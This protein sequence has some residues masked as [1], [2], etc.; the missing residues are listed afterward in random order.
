VDQILSAVTRIT[1]AASATIKGVDL[2]VS[3]VPIDELTLTASIEAM[4][5]RYNSFSDGTF[6]V[7]NPI[8]GGN[9]TLA[10][11]PAPASIPCGGVLPPNYNALTGSWD[12]KGNH[13][14]Q[15]PPFS[16]SMLAQYEI[17]TRSGRFDLN[18]SWTH[19]GHYYADADNG[20]GQIPPS[21]AANDM[22]KLIDVLNASL[23]WTSNNATL[24]VRLWAKNLTN[25]HYWSY[26]TEISFA[27]LY[28]PAPP[29]TY[30]VTIM[31]R[32]E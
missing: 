29:R 10:V 3:A 21:A 6:F 27:T 15:T 25:V 16:L 30:G 1:N 2:D 14:I 13:T 23:G 20:K 28:S 4:K 26:A 8:M 19:T 18:L 17:A 32:F 9:C 12:L 24:E 7:Y 5:G 31:K 11:A 22:Q